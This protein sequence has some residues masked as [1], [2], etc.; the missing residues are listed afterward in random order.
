MP[1]LPLL[2]AFIVLVLAAVCLVLTLRARPWKLPDCTEQPSQSRAESEA[3][4]SE[5]E[6][7]RIYL[8]SAHFLQLRTTAIVRT[9]L[10]V[11]FACA[12]IAA[13]N[14]S[15]RLPAALHIAGAAFFLACGSLYVRRAFLARRRVV[16]LRVLRSQ[17]LDRPVRPVSEAAIPHLV[18]QYKIYTEDLG[19]IGSRQASTSAW[20]TSIVSALAAVIAYL[21]KEQ[22]L[23]SLT[24]VGIAPI[25]FVGIMLCVIWQFHARSYQYLYDAKFRVLHELERAGLPFHCFGRESQLRDPRRVR[26]TTLESYLSAT[27]VVLFGL[28]LGIAVWNLAR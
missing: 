4:D 10:F 6:V 21:A 7:D 19:N 3:C 8:H 13:A 26:F 22:P 14:V 24:Y 20:Y 16:E 23:Q 2:A 9:V 25:S 18:E 28:L 12:T 5:R 17:H 11:L 27:F 1:D 15:A